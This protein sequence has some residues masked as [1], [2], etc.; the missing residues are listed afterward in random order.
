MTRRVPYG[1]SM[2]IMRDRPGDRVGYDIDVHVCVRGGVHVP[3]VM[4][5]AAT[6]I[7]VLTVSVLNCALI[8]VNDVTRETCAA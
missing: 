8:N 2:T 1:P 5:M 3:C 7:F 6:L 4:L